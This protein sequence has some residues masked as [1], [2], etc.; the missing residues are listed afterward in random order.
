MK[1]VAWGV[2]STAKIARERVLPGMRKSS[3]LEVR[4]IASR[5]DARARRTAGAVAIPETYGA[6]E[7][8]IQRY[9]AQEIASHVRLRRLIAATV[10]DS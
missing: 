9:P 4:A 5:D 2:L 6:C 10:R 8:Q 3:L 1:K 7:R